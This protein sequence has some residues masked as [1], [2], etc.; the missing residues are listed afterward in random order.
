LSLIRGLLSQTRDSAGSVDEFIAT[1][2]SRVQAL[3]RAHD[4]IT[5]DRWAPAR[6]Q[7]LI[8]VEAGA[9]LGEQ[10]DRVK[11]TGPN[12]LLTPSAFTVLALVIHELLTNAAKYGALSDGGTVTIDWHVDPDGSLLLHWRESGGPA[13]V[14]PT[15][16]GFGS[17]VIERSIPYD[18]DG[19]AE[20]AY[21]LAGLEAHFCIP[22]AHIVSVLPDV[23]STERAKPVAMP[24]PEL[25]KGRNVLLVEDN[26]IIAMD[27]E[28]ALRDLGADVVTAGSVSRARE[29]IALGSIDFAVLDFNLGNETS[30]PV[31]DLLAEQGIGFLFATGYGDGLDLPERFG[32]I[33]LIKKPYSGVT[34]AQAIGPV[35]EGA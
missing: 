13:V 26:M 35:L 23:S 16:R 19:K 34:L 6:L 14:A 21:R 33:T 28:D 27:G 15:R 32:D 11:Q 18:L 30:L 9:Y 2:E 8:E 7:D 5:A 3:A 24:T 17:T 25:L 29:A 22:S 20:L 12:V 31:A 10:R 1:L 4:Q